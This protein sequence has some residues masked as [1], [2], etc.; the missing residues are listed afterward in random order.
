MSKAQKLTGKVNRQE[1]RERLSLVTYH[2]SPDL[3]PIP[4]PLSLESKR[5]AF[6]LIELLVVTVVIVA[7]MSVIFRLTGIV[8]GTSAQETTVFR[9]QCLENCLSGYYA[10]FGSYPPVPLQNAS[11]NIFR[12]T[13]SDT[14]WVQSDSP[15]DSWGEGV[16]FTAN[17]FYH[18]V[19]AA[20]KAQPVRASFPPPD[21]IGSETSRVAYEQ[22]Q[23]RVQSALDDGVFDDNEGDKESVRKWVGR[24]LDDVSEAPGFLNP[25]QKTTSYNELQLFRFGVMSFLLPRY[26]FMLQCA[27]GSGG[28][29]T[30]AAFNGAIDNFRQWTDNNYLPPRMDTGTSY[31]S[32]EEFCN[33]ID[34]D[35]DWQIDLIPNQA[36]CARWMPNLKGTV[37]SGPQRKFFGVTVAEH[38]GTIPEVRSA[39]GFALYFPG[40]YNG[41]GNSRGYPLLHYTVKDGWGRDLYYYSPAPYQMYVLWSAGANGKTFPP[42]VDLAQLNTDQRKTAIGWMSDDIKYMTTGK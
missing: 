35:D 33:V 14:P 36:A 30:A 42:W 26:R 17:G 40:G 38:G 9:M 39:P 4:Y 31:E 11:R 18:S 27:K 2:L 20:C 24:T 16:D 1:G 21:R 15:N 7:L 8:G 13:D 29:G 23:Q 22:Y 12:R 28:G 34:S 3:S 19:E 25:H 6:T 32:W 5:A 10:T 37:V 41:G